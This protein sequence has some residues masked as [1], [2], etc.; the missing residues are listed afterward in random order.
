MHCHLT[1]TCLAISQ[2][3]YELTC[4]MNLVLDDKK[5]LA[6]KVT[7][8]DAI[9][10]NKIHH[11]DRTLQED[12]SAL[13]LHLRAAPSSGKREIWLHKRRPLLFPCSQAE[14]SQASPCTIKVKY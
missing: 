10:N 9:S 3:N 4:S 13:Y 2:K 12:D 8:N 6:A 1:A 11:R 7:F 5:T 14:V